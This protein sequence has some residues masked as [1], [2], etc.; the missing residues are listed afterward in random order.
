[1]FFP[2]FVISPWKSG[3]PFIWT[4][5]NFL[6]PRMLCTKRGRNSPSGSG[7]QFFLKLRQCILAISI[8]SSLEQEQGPLFEQ[9]WTHFLKECFVPSLVQL[10]H[11]RGPG[12]DYFF[13]FVN[14]LT[15]FRYYLPLEKE[16]N[17]HLNKLESPLPKDALCQVWLK[18][19]EWLGDEDKNVKVYNNDDDKKNDDGQRT[20]FYLGT[21]V[22]VTKKA[23]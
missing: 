12:E 6:H 14:L 13:I 7:E 4:N 3:W 20:N 9:T 10:S 2:C 17:L 15:L 5:L 21:S 8:F 1:M 22:K 23:L 16:R 18:L 19:T 11:C